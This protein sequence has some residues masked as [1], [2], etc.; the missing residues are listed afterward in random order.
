M[1]E[2]A[3]RIEALAEAIAAAGEGWPS[4]TARAV[5]LLDAVRLCVPCP[6]C[7]PEDCARYRRPLGW[8]DDGHA[9]CGVCR[10][11]RDDGWTE[12]DGAPAWAATAAA[13]GP[14]A[15]LRR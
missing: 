14:A 2:D 11:S 4:A 13:S 1:I 3:Q 5:R 8:I 15:E 6:A 10:Y 12:Y 7:D 9:E